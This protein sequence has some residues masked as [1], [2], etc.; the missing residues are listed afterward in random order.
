M[1]KNKL[2]QEGPVT[3][4]L[5]KTAPAEMRECFHS[6]AYV[7]VFG[8]CLEEDTVQPVSEHEVEELLS[9]SKGCMLSK[10]STIYSWDDGSTAAPGGSDAGSVSNKTCF[11]MRIVL[12]VSV[13]IGYEWFRM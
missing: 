10:G 2:H 11:V 7:Y 6:Y 9:T 4:F 3:F 1:E 8:P 13:L 5:S 12:A